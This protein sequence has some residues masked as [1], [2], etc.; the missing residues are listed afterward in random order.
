VYGILESRIYA[1]SFRFYMQTNF[2]TLQEKKAK[3]TAHSKGSKN[4]KLGSYFGDELIFRD[5][6]AQAESGGRRVKKTIKR[7]RRKRSEQQHGN[8]SRNEENQK[9]RKFSPNSDSPYVFQ[10]FRRKIHSSQEKRKNRKK[11]EKQKKNKSSL[12]LNHFPPDPDASNFQSLIIN[13]ESSDSPS[14]Y[15]DCDNQISEP[16]LYKSKPNPRK[17]NLPLNKIVR[18]NKKAQL[19]PQYSCLT[20]R[21]NGDSHRN[22]TRFTNRPHT[23]SGINLADYQFGTFKTFEFEQKKERAKSAPPGGQRIKHFRAKKDSRPPTRQRPPP[24][25]LH[26]ELL[27]PRRPSSARKKSRRPSSA[28]FAKLRN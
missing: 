10:N 6:A 12:E 23:S 14:S 16:P 13:Q 1:L 26:L 27:K 25:A 15:S 19:R 2:S 4:L 17:F 28:Q 22:T 8:R 20:E 11:T 18:E 24:E 7:I 3:R 5:R 9:I 21:I